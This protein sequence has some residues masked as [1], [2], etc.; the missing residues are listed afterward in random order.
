MHQLILPIE[1]L[2]AEAMER[3]FVPWLQGVDPGWS[4]SKG[5]FLQYMKEILGDWDPPLYRFF[6][7][8]E[9]HFL[10]LLDP[11]L[12]LCMHEKERWLQLYLPYPVRNWR[13]ADA[14]NSEAL[15]EFEST[16]DGMRE[17][18]GMPSRVCRRIRSPYRELLDG[19]ARLPDPHD[20]S[21]YGLL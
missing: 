11:E 5:S 10:A 15:A 6:D 20:R 7:F 1:E 2:Q 12:F 4:E 21:I 14:A 18:R 13:Y 3:A 17:R 16:I 8:D 9:Q 19:S